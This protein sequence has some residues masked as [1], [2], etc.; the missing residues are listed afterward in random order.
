MLVLLCLSDPTKHKHPHPLVY[1]GYVTIVCI[2]S[3]KINKIILDECSTGDQTFILG[4]QIF[5]DHRSSR[6]IDQKF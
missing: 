6:T 1:L 2:K 3:P 5:L 4:L